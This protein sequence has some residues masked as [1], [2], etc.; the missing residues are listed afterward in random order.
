MALVQVAKAAPLYWAATVMLEGVDAKGSGSLVRFRLRQLSSLPGAFVVTVAGAYLGS[1]FGAS[2]GDDQPHRTMFNNIV[3][4]VGFAFW[5]VVYGAG[6]VFAQSL[7][8]D[9]KALDEQAR[10]RALKA[11]VERLYR[12]ES[13]WMPLKL[14]EPTARTEAALLRFA[15]SPAITAPITLFL[16]A[17][18]IGAVLVYLLV[19]FR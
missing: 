4:E 12:E 16:L 8:N 9:L 6:M 1:F 5:A 18:G 13:S 10:V 19:F 17:A 3:V 14:F 15:Q 7:E 2:F 11:R